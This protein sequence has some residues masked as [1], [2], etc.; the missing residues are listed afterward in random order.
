[1]RTLL[2]LTFALLAM[3]VAYAGPGAHGPNGEHLD[4]QASMAGAG[5]GV[6]SIEAFT[7][8]F[9]LVGHLA[10]GELS[11]MIDRFETNEP[12]LNAIL[13]VQYRQLKAKANFHA[14]G[15]DY[16]ID[17]PAFLAAISQPGTHGLL[18]T[19]IDGDES[20]LLEGSLQVGAAR[21][22][23]AHEHDQWRPWG[24]AALGAAGLI[25]AGFALRQRGR[26]RQ[27][28]GNQS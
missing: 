5:P 9:E 11:V 21:E 19:L 13:E 27:R 4:A 20:D 6:P 12:V 1:M 3:S 16:A 7:E 25:A 2:L 26:R 14:D 17:D 18:F 10:N 22:D 24:L 8:S 28:G 23:H 15:G